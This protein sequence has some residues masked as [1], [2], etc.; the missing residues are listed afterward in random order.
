MPPNKPKRDA[1]GK[2]KSKKTG[3]K[4][5]PGGVQK[6]RGRR[7]DK[8]A[9]S[10]LYADLY[11][12]MPKPVTVIGLKKNFSDKELR[13]LM[14]HNGM[15]INDYDPRSQSY[16]EKTKQAK[17]DILVEAAPT[18]IVPGTEPEGHNSDGP[19]AKAKGPAGKARSQNK[20]SPA[21]K[22]RFFPASGKVPTR[23]DGAGQFRGS[24]APAPPPSRPQKPSYLDSEE[25]DHSDE[26][27][28]N[29]SNSS[30]LDSDDY[31]DGDASDSDS[32]NGAPQ[33]NANSVDKKPQQPARASQKRG[34]NAGSG[35]GGSG[36]G[37]RP[38][39]VLK[40]GPITGQV[41]GASIGNRPM[42]QINLPEYPGTG[43]RPSDQFAARPSLDALKLDLDE[44]LSGNRTAADVMYLHDNI[45]MLDDD[46]HPLAPID[47]PGT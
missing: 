39:A 37:G 34:Y 14:K 46:G 5:A 21:G 3:R 16:S 20:S 17:C 43:K 19:P 15:L 36:R 30:I 40:K 7:V 29:G 32:D 25:S 24:K 1:Q 8:Q 4:E 33:Y 12:K 27:D 41:P 42:P 9:L 44:H 47:E 28:D 26:S 13:V 10:Q 2:K 18:M 31:D 23:P 38:A 6:R 22:P 45:G 11:H 35:P